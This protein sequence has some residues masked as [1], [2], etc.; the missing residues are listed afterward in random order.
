M[1]LHNGALAVVE[2]AVQSFVC[3]GSGC[4]HAAILSAEG[5]KRSASILQKGAMFKAS[6]IDQDLS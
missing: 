6:T 5:V 3:S 2:L 4:Q 1:L